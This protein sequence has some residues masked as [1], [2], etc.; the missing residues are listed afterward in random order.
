MKAKLSVLLES[1]KGKAQNVVAKGSL[2]G[3]IMM[4]RSV[5]KDP[6]TQPQM[7]ARQRFV[8]MARLWKSLTNE[9]RSTWKVPGDG[10]VSSYARF[11][12]QNTNL[13]SIDV[14]PLMTVNDTRVTN[15]KATLEMDWNW[16]TRQAT[17]KIVSGGT[18]G[19]CSIMV[20][21]AAP[22]KEIFSIDTYKPNIIGTVIDDGRTSRNLFEIIDRYGWKLTA[23]PMAARMQIFVIS[24]I[25]G[26]KYLYSDA[27]EDFNP[28]EKGR[29]YIEDLTPVLP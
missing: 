29:F 27:V 25:S 5:G 21:M 13:H 19:Q 3:Q 4:I 12:Y 2:R 23:S 10:F 22:T 11:S 24:R 26:F 20:T 15:Y 28:V 16:N 14:M 7:M 9:Q 6:R 1:L 17:M 18:A 8:N